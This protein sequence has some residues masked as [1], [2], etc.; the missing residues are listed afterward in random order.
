MFS[1]SEIGDGISV[2]V[3]SCLAAKK[4]KHLGIN[5]CFNV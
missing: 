4:L 2:R 3:Y 5:K 1:C